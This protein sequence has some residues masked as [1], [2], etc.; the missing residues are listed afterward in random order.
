MKLRLERVWAWVGLALMAM[1]LLS[2]CASTPEPVFTTDPIV[3]GGTNGGGQT[4]NP[5]PE[6]FVFQIGD[7]VTV[8]FSDVPETIQPHIE[9]IKEDGN[10]TLPLIGSVK[11]VGKSPGQLQQEIHDR[12]V[13]KFYVRVNVTVTTAPTETSFYVMGEVRSPG[14]K[15]YTGVTTVTKAIAAAGGLTDFASKDL[16]LIR[17]KGQK[18]KVNYKKAVRDPKADPQVFPGDSINVDRSFL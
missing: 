2:G 16:V 17:A 11:A 12:Y 18:V 4:T 15:P 1:M 6:S 13:P 14:P 3:D 8:N 10:V 9:R 5:R 7:L